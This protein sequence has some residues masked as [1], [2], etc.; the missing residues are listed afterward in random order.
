M[1]IREALEDELPDILEL[2]KELDETGFDMGT[3]CAAWS[4]MRNYPDYK[5]YAA[6]DKDELIGTFCLLIAD[7]IGHGGSAF[8]VL[9][10]V[11]VK[12]QYQSRG[13]GKMMVAEALNIAK[14]KKCYKLILSSA[15]HRGRSHE[16][17]RKLGFEQHGLSFTMFI[18]ET[19][20]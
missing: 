8:A 3:M 1:N 4:K 14:C 9:E 10:N 15:K 12:P 13:V 11:V 19:K 18:Q 7:N 5:L 17:Y 2:L 16:F 20:T 6:M